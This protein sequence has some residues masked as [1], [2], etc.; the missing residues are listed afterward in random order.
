MTL[1]GACDA[2]PCVRAK[3]IAGIDPIAKSNAARSASRAAVRPDGGS[4]RVPPP[5]SRPR[6]RSV[7]QRQACGAVDRHAEHACQSRD[8]PTSGAR[9]RPA[10]RARGA[11]PDPA[12]QDGNRDWRARPPGGVARLGGRE[13]LSRGRRSCRVLRDRHSGSRLTIP[14]AGTKTGKEDRVPLSSTAL[15]LP[16]ALPRAAAVGTRVCRATRRPAVRGG[17]HRRDATHEGCGRAAR[18]SVDVSCLVLGTH[19]PPL[20][21]RWPR[22]RMRS[23]TRS[24]HLSTKARGVCHSPIGS[25]GHPPWGST[26]WPV[27]RSRPCRARRA[28]SGTGL[29]ARSKPAEATR[30][31]PPIPPASRC[32]PTATPRGGCRGSSR[33]CRRPCRPTSIASTPWTGARRWPCSRLPSSMRRRCGTL[34]ASPQRA[35]TIEGS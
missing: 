33:R 27:T 20:R 19:V 3:I 25:H 23:A 35:T 24:R 2:A 29:P 18:P 11:S 6:R 12:D 4:A 10:P 30:S 13:R 5:A 32:R 14:G 9:S 21:A 7:A 34:L 1:A 22:W 15:A 26:R 31:R 8:G 17:I 28:K 16:K